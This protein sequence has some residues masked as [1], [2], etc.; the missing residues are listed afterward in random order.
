MDS[1][2]PT[3]LPTR[4]L[5]SY[6]IE[7]CHAEPTGLLRAV[8]DLGKDAIRQQFEGLVIFSLAHRVRML[9]ASSTRYPIWDEGDEVLRESGFESGRPMAEKCL[10]RDGWGMNGK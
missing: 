1:K 4:L 5:L 10:S 8:G 7:D 6:L 3:K 2:L 9:N